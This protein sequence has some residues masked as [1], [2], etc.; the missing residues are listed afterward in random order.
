MTIRASCA[1]SRKMWRNRRLSG[2]VIQAADDVSALGV[3]FHPAGILGKPALA[4]GSPAPPRKSPGAA[5]FSL[6][7]QSPLFPV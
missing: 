2:L 6:S 5:H 1:V 4:R 3:A 7:D